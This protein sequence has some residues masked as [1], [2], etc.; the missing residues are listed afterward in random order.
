MNIRNLTIVI[1]ILFSIEVMSFY[2]L[3]QYQD[4]LSNK[5]GYYGPIQKT[6]VFNIEDREGEFRNVKVTYDK[7]GFKRWGDV[8]IDKRKIFIIGDQFTNMPYVNNGEE[9]YAYLEKAFPDVEF[10]VFGGGGY[11]SLQEYLILDSYIDVIKPDLVLWQFCTSD[12]ANNH[13]EYE[14]R[15]MVMSKNR[16][17]PFLENGEIVYKRPSKYLALRDIS[18]S[19]DL[20]YSAFI[21]YRRSNIV[22]SEFIDTLTTNF[23]NTPEAIKRDALDTTKEIFSLAKKRT[24]DIPLYMFSAFEFTD[25]EREICEFSGIDCIEGVGEKLLQSESAGSVIHTSHSGFPDFHWNVTGNLI[26]GNY[27]TN[28]FKEKMLLQ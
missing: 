16:K 1:G 3:S 7:N 18:Y 4:E 12:F 8:D 26:V 11:G 25:K 23:E 27:L 13:Y 2:V 9:Y 5:Y 19:F 22:Y 21:K 10:F 24:G 28:Y 14:I 20:L 17:L 6:F 15:T